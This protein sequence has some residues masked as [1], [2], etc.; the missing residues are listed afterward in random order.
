M[1]Q[2]E[3]WAQLI[4]LDWMMQPLR[5]VKMSSSEMRGEGGFETTKQMPFAAGT[6]AGFGRANRGGRGACTGLS[7]DRET[8]AK[9]QKHLP[10]EGRVKKDL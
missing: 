9:G 5:D 2:C 7:C 6:P 1:M 10:L 8:S 4:Y 3:A